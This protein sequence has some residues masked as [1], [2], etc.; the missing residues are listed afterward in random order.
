MY[1]LRMKVFLAVLAGVLLLLA[2]KLVQLQVIQGQ[3]HRRAAEEAMRS[4]EVLPVIRGKITDR[5]GRIL[6]LDEPCFDLC[7]HYRFLTEDQGW[8]RRQIRLLA[9]RERVPAANAADLYK[10]RSDTTWAIAREQAEA[11]GSDLD[12]EVRRI[13]ERV[14]A[15]REIVNRRH[16]T[17]VTIRD[18]EQ[19]HPVLT[20]LDE[21]TALRLKKQVERMAGALVRSS[22]RRWYPYGP[23]ACHVIGMTGRVWPEEMERLNLSE[24]RV[25]WLMRMRHNY[26][27]GDRIGKVGVERMCETALRGQRGYRRFRLTGEELLREPGV[28]GQDVHLT[29]DV[30][31]QRKAA[32]LLKAHGYTGSA[33]VLSV[34]T[35][36]APRCEVLAMVS[37]PTYD[38]NSY[39]AEYPRLVGDAIGLPLLHR[40][41]V[42]R[43]QPGSTV[44]PLAALAGLGSG[45]IGLGTQIT[46]RG[47]L[48]NPGAFRCW[49]YKSYH[50]GHGPLNVVEALQHS[51]NVFFYEVGNRV[52]AR[53]LCDWF[54]MFGF[55]EKPGMGLPSER[56][57][58]VPTERWLEQHF[59]RRWRPGDARLMC[60]GQGPLTA[61]PVHLANAM[62]TIAREGIFLSPQ[63]VLEGGPHQVRRDL[64]L[65]PSHIAAVREGMHRVVNDR[66]GTA[67]KYFHGAGIEP[68]D[69]VEISG[70]TG[71]ATTAPQ[72]IDSNQN[73]RIDLGD[74]IVRRGD[75]A[76]F[77][78]FAPHDRPE[79]A[80]AVAVEYVDGGGGRIAGPIARELVRACQEL[81]YVRR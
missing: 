76:W 26:L 21:A 70:K 77:V 41:I 47:Y 29:L 66:Q 49:I 80:F 81:G 10:R 72:R 68:I 63:L 62:A 65:P 50:V 7:L 1:R 33:V 46:C 3:D 35:P 53:R 52:G 57:G 30:V 20:G 61:T 42:Q 45:S 58:T 11:L 67:Y 14:R 25:D 43:Y 56:A 15:V 79:V 78:G 40:A 71:T 38:L 39:P 34:G 28:Q 9:R 27:P 6:A 59:R 8:I 69:G 22:F 73:G 13:V 4:V 24:D 19:F 55:G 37:V 74:R 51:C 2:S 60:V 54:L 48:D 18:E 36:E 64:P 17:E 5:H 44:K 12:G 23:D 16:V 75:T 31:L 32:E